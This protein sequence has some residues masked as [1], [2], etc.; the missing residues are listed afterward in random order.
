MLIL[1]QTLCKVVSC[2]LV[3][4]SGI[5]YSLPSDISQGLHHRLLLPRVLTR[6]VWI[7]AQLVEAPVYGPDG[8]VEF[9]MHS[10]M[11]VTGTTQDGPLKIE[12][13]TDNQNHPYIRVKDFTTASTGDFVPGNP[14]TDS[15]V[16]QGQTRLTNDQFLDSARGTGV[17][18]DAL[19]E[20]A[21]YRVGTTYIGRLNTCQDLLVRILRRLNIQIAPGT[22]RWFNLFNQH[23]A[24]SYGDVSR[25]M[26]VTQYVEGADAQTNTLLGSFDTPTDLCR[27]P[28]P[29]VPGAALV[30]RD[31]A[32][33]N[34][35][36]KGKE[37]IFDGSKTEVALNKLASSLPA[38]DLDVT[39]TDNLPTKDLSA[40]VKGGT[41]KVSLVRNAGALTRYVAVGKDVLAGLGAVATVA[42]AVFVIL[43]FVDHNWVG[44]AIGGVGLA[45]GIAAGFALSGPIG[46]IVGGAIAALFA[47]K[48]RANA[49]GPH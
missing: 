6:D 18:T 17:V 21:I 31:G 5:A 3:S 22:Q 11:F 24:R 44:G 41:T 2:A 14:A 37:A 43:D 10:Y 19:Y 4:L 7:I 45:A 30:K 35:P 34:T 1:P 48:F 46:W 8:W 28:T 36:I 40:D 33:S 26:D 42:G 23:G 12:V 13:A 25:A 20:D 38:D 9:P 47:S 49:T 27:D 15:R 32:C 16:L 39:S 29:P